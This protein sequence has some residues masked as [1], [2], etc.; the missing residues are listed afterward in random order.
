MIIE[1]N[2]IKILKLKKKK[3]SEEIEKEL[4]KIEKEIVNLKKG[5]ELNIKKIATET[6][7]EIIKQIIGTEVNNSN[8]SAIV[9]DITKKEMDKHT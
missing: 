6:S 9:D 2:L 8:V 7:S 5:S 3:F 4:K 1:K